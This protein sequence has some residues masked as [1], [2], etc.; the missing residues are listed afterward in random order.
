MTDGKAWLEK[1]GHLFQTSASDGMNT[2]PTIV[3]RKP[4]PFQV[5]RYEE[6]EKALRRCAIELAYINHGVE[7]C[8]SGLCA[9]GE[10]KDCIKEAERLLG[11][12]KDWPEV[13][14]NQ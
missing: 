9:T 4:H 12:M 6:I 7:N 5:R 2:N 13:K 11:P 3:Q 1:Y 10:G 14:E 8:H